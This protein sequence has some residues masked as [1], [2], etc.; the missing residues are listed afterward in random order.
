MH[1]PMEEFDST[2]FKN[3]SSNDEDNLENLWMCGASKASMVIDGSKR[4]KE[5]QDYDFVPMMLYTCV[6]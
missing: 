4:H 3:F 2:S 1:I 6:G 5:V